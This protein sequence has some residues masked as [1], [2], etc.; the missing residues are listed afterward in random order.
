VSAFEAVI[1]ASLSVGSTAAAYLPYIDIEVKAHPK[2]TISTGTKVRIQDNVDT[3]ADLVCNGG[4]VLRSI[5]G[6]L[7]RCMDFSLLTKLAQN[8]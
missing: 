3:L 2:V 6:K 4:P 5:T 1:G 7:L 8:K